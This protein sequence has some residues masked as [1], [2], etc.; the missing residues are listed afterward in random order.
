[1]TAQFVDQLPVPLDFSSE[2]AFSHLMPFNE[3]VDVSQNGVLLHEQE[4]LRVITRTSRS[5]ACNHPILRAGSGAMITLAM[6]E[7]VQINIEKL[8]DDMQAHV[9]GGVSD[10]AFSMAVT[11]GTNPSWYRHYKT[12]RQ[13]K[14]LTAQIFLGITQ[15]MGRDPF[16]YVVGADPKPRLPSATVLTSTFAS[17]LSTLGIDPYEGERARKLARQFPDALQEIL[18]LHDRLADD[19]NSSDEEDSRDLGE[20]PSGP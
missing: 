2:G 13:S 16:E 5:Y 11:G 4:L 17:L 6:E 3:G 14:R 9:D 15:A 19:A 18:A 12:G 1:M 7:G 8:R 20:G 10:R